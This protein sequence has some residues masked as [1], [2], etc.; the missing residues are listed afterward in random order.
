MHTIET[1]VVEQIPRGLTTFKCNLKDFV[2]FT[3]FAEL[4]DSAALTHLII[5]YKQEDAD[6]LTIMSI[7]DNICSMFIYFEFD[8]LKCYINRRPFLVV[9]S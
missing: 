5:E 1:Y 3:R 4:I 8:L 2:Q 6:I 7:F 9:Y